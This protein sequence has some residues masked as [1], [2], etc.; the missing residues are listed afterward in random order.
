MNMFGDLLSLA[1]QVIPSQEVIY[2][3]YSGRQVNAGGIFVTTYLPGVPKAIGSLQSVNRN[4][5]VQLGLNFEKT[6]VSWFVPD[7]DAD[8]IARGISGDVIEYSGQRYQLDGSTDWL[9]Q[10]GWKNLIGVRIGPA[11]GATTNA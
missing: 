10:D 11:T 8:D 3:K 7:L 4:M 6:Y 5:Y 9:A 2:F 1:L